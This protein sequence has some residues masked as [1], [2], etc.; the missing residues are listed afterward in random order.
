VNTRISNP[1]CSPV[2]RSSYR[3]GSHSGS[4]LFMLRLVAKPSLA[5][6]SGWDTEGTSP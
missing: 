1:T 2:A 4:S 6:N 3:C 5:L